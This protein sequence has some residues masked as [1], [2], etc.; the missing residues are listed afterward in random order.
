MG[1]KGVSIY[2]CCTNLYLFLCL[3]I[4]SLVGPVFVV[5]G[6]GSNG[7]IGGGMELA[8]IVAVAVLVML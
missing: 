7:V 3:V 2:T 4:I 8:M 6:G 5:I 1:N